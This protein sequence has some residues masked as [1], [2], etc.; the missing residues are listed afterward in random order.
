V[1]RIDTM[2]VLTS[3][4]APKDARII[5][6]ILKSMGIEDYEPRVVHQLLEFMHR[7]ACLAPPTAALAVRRH[8]TDQ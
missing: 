8:T 1:V 6:L 4:E 2:D 5:G 3:G 7:M